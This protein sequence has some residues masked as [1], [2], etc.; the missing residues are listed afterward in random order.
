M[1]KYASK[2]HRHERTCTGG[3][4]RVYKG[5]CS[6][7]WTTRTSESPNRCGTTCT[8]PPLTVNVGLTP[9][10]LSDCYKVHWVARHVPLSVSVV[11]N[12]PGHEHVQCIVTD[13][14]TDKLVSDMMYILRVMSDAA[15]EKNKNA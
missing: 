15:Y 10:N 9:N 3:V 2:L 6:N 12:V 5:Q 8:E 4:C 1:S 11:S 7:V 13:R 14:D